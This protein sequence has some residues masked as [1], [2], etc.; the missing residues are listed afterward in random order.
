MKGEKIMVVVECLGI[1]LL[2]ASALTLPVWVFW[3]L[4]D[5]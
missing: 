1:A 2:F 5:H 4:L 3:C